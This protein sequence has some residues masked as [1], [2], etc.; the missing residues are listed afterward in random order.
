MSVVVTGA[1]SGT[2]NAAA[3]LLAERDLNVAVTDAD[4]DAAKA[5]A[6]ELGAFWAVLDVTS[7]ASIRDAMEEAG[8]AIGPAG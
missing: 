4:E 3:C 8:A 2:G 5:V 1:S 6:G 7:R